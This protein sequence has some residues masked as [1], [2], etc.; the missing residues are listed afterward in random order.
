MTLPMV[1]AVTVLAGCGGA[2]VQGKAVPE[3]KDAAAARVDVGKLDTGKYPI[4][5]L[6][7]LG[8]AGSPDAGR[9]LEAQL[10]A[11]Y[12]LGPW[13]VD[14]TLTEGSAPA[15]SIVL[16]KDDFAF[17]LRA[18]VAAGL[19]GQPFVVGFVADR[20][21]ADSSAPMSLRN[22]VLRFADDR[23]AA[24]AVTSMTASTM[25]LPVDASVHPVLIE[26]PVA[27]PVPGHPA[28]SGSLQK[29]ND[30]DTIKQEVTALTAHGP[31]VVFDVAQHPNGPD[32]AAAL[33]ARAIDLQLPL[34]DGF[35]PSNPTFFPELP[36]DPTGLVARTLPT[37]PD[38]ATPM[39]GSAYP[40]AGALHAEANPVLV[41]PQLAAAGVDE[42]SIGASTLYRAKDAAAAIALAKD[43]EDAATKQP[44]TQSAAGVP[45][46]PDS[47]CLLVADAN[48]LVPKYLCLASRD[49]YVFKTSARDFTRAQQQLAAQYRMLGG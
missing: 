3:G 1:V 6:A 24:D 45:G 39:S 17:N 38:E 18:R 35:Q 25:T 48:G 29:Y 33:A 21:N 26:P 10:M 12:V 47:R 43:F 27:I 7:P 42:V 49:Q 14:D 32:A 9:R 41:G 20:H 46:L 36:L 11:P 5:P 30:D 34:L 15:G 13:Q 8:V 40:P 22:G 28:S 2:P 37:A 16:S 4:A 23:A 31:F 19:Y 44:S